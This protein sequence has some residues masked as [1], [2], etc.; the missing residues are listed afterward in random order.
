MFIPPR[1]DRMFKKV[2]ADPSDPAP[3]RSFLGGVLNV[4]GEDLV[5]LSFADSHTHPSHHDNRE[6]IVDV[7]LKTISGRDIDIEI[8]LAPEPGFHERLVYY[9]SS[10]LA[11]QLSVGRSY[12]TLAQAI[13]IAVTGFRLNYISDEHFHHRF[14]LYD[15]DH[16]VRLTDILE[17]NVLELPK[18]PRID[19]G[20][21]LWKWLRFISA[22][23]PEEL[24]MA[25]TLDPVI[26][27]AATKVE[28]FSQD[29]GLQ[30]YY[31]EQDRKERDRVTRETDERERAEALK[32]REAA[33]ESRETSIDERETAVDEREVSIEGRETAIEQRNAALEQRSAALEEEVARQTAALADRDTE[34][35]AR[36]AKLRE[37]EA[38]LRAQEIA[39]EA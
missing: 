29:W 13:T 2:F 38:A 22:R 32:E 20:T 14:H 25:A 18:L 6:G 27:D 4:P 1:F 16:H 30:W 5:A 19:D 15:K 31:L 11:S 37:R 8:Q 26:A 36:E 23:D 33:I 21:L 39:A 7:R 9:T 17:V 24:H 35:G 10:M 28:R 3:L 12:A 34:L